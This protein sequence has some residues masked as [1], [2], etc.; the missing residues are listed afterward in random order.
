MPDLN[1]MPSWLPVDRAAEVIEQVSLDGCSKC[2]RRDVDLAYHVLNPKTLNWKEDLVPMLRK[3][4]PEFQVVTPREWLSRLRASEGDV[5]RN[6]SRKLIEFWEGKYG[7][8]SGKQPDV[9]ADIEAGD[10][11]SEE[12]G[13]ERTQGLTFETRLTIEDSSV[14]ARVQNPVSD[15]LMARIVN[16]WLGKWNAELR[17]LEQ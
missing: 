11:I 17:T 3:V 15:G 2:E 4:M 1:E 14:L 16:V 10:S 7:G 12:K 6:P 8:A 13:S 5:K 9:S